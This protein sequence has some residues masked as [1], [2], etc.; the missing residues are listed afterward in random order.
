MRLV[1]S[2]CYDREKDHQ[3]ESSYLMDHANGKSA[4]FGMNEEDNRKKSIIPYWS[5]HMGHGIY[6]YSTSIEAF[7]EDSMIS[8]ASAMQLK[9]RRN[10]RKDDTFRA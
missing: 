4:L 2:C 5:Y 6:I 3:Q 8:K 1:Q 7:L 9:S 10:A